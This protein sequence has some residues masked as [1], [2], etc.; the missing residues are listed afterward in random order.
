MNVHPPLCLF[1]CEVTKHPL[2]KVLETF[3]QKT[4]S[5]YWPVM[6]QWTKVLNFFF[7][8]KKKK[9]INTPHSSAIFSD[10][11]IFFKNIIG[12]FFRFFLFYFVFSI[13]GLFPNSFLL[14]LDLLHIIIVLFLDLPDYFDIFWDLK[15]KLLM[16]LLTVTEVTTEQ[17]KMEKMGPNN[18]KALFFGP[19]PSTGAKSWHA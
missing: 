13:F 9:W 3:G 4:N 16:L 15:K 19:K 14:L 18:I 10:F 11:W 6:T 1:V 8:Q 17:K 7:L 12:N 5:W 2:P